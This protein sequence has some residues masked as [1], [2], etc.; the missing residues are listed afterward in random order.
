MNKYGFYTA[1]GSNPEDKFYTGS[2]SGVCSIDEPL[3]S[4]MRQNPELRKCS[5]VEW[6]F[7]EMRS[8]YNG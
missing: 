1:R 7:E 2:L 8:N 5:H 3:A 6:S 4:M